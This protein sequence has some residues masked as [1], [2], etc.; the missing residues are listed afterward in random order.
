VQEYPRIRQLRAADR[1]AQPVHTMTPLHA[2]RRHVALGFSLI[3]LTIAIAIMGVLL[4]AILVPL[5]TQVQ[6]RNVASTEKTM[7]EIKDA[8]LGF[9]AVNGRLP[10]PAT[11]ASLGAEAF[12]TANAGTAANGRCASFW[13]FVPARTLGITPVT[14]TGFALDAWGTNDNRIRY[15]VSNDSVGVT[16]RPFTT[17]DGLRSA[18]F[19]SIAAVPNLL[20]VCSSASGVTPG[21]GCAA[22]GTLASNAVAVI[23]SVGPNA[24]TGGLGADERQN[25]N[26]RDESSTDRIFVSHPATNITNNT[27]DDIVTWV[28]INTLVNR[29]VGA[30]QLP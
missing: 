29:M 4:G 28:S 24:S 21:V 20:N 7:S 26:P 18:T 11:E 3:E 13:G 19:A 2:M 17:T 12:D 25:P 5:V 8:L 14:N 27:F 1:C 30:G 10:C 6:Q 15:A 23:W 16:A 9:A 22:G